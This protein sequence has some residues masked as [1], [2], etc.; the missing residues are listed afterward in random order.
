MDRRDHTFILKLE[1]KTEGNFI[2][3]KGPF[4][5][6]RDIILFFFMGLANGKTN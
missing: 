4:Q 1:R 3:E 6:D 2:S 5:I